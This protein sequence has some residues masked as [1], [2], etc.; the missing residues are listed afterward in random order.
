MLAILG[1]TALAAFI[2]LIL[3]RRLHVLTALVLVP[4]A[5][6]LVAGFAGDLG[7]MMVDGLA[8]VTPTGLL[9]LFS[10]LYFGTMID[11]GLFDP[12]INLIMRIVKN[13]PLRI[14]IG[15]SALT[16]IVA[17]DGDGTSTF[18]LISLAMLPIYARI[19]MSKLVLMTCTALP[20]YIVNSAP[21]GGPTT[22]AMAALELSVSEVFVP[23]IPSL[24]IGLVFVFVMAVILGKRERAR[25]G[26]SDGE[27]LSD[28]RAQDHAGHARAR[29]MLAAGLDPKNGTTTVATAIA[30]EHGTIAER[31][32][33]LKRPRLLWINLILTAAVM[34]TLVTEV[35][36][37][38]VVFIIGFVLA[39]IVNYR[40]FE[41]TEARIRSHA[42]N[43]LWATVLIFAAG[44]FTGIFNGTGMI[45]QMASALVAVIPDRLGPQMPVITAV[46]SFIG[47]QVVSAD[48][49]Y[50]GVLPV[51]AESAGSFGISEGAI[52][53]AALLAQVGYGFSAIVASPLL[54]ASLVKVEFVRHQRFMALWA[55]GCF[56]VMVG[57]ALLLGTIA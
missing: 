45:E 33:E 16:A 46:V 30:E 4:I 53:R 41:Q 22:R 1:F 35:L 24:L 20:F 40:D 6:A 3:T 37:S 18:I 28:T 43:A 55:L 23:L 27:I 19:G 29:H 54:L 17:L 57:L 56:V 50:Y 8:R 12:V 42:G 47:T 26:W 14:A 13:D 7:P 5:A 10:V 15:T 21:W 36:P 51:L 44:I 2:T 39:L 31:N 9:V 52:A 49:F 48:A 32:P 11:A 38:S 34:V 25:L